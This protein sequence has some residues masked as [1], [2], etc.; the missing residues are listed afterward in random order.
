MKY[1]LLTII[2]LYWFIVPPKRRRKC[3]FKESCSN[4]VWRIT[5][6]NGFNAG[7]NA[8]L[9]RNRHCCPGYA[10]YKYNGHYNLKTI[11]GLILKDDEIAET[12]LNEKNPI[13]INFDNPTEN[14]N[15]YIN[16]KS[17]NGVIIKFDYNNFSN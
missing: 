9:F 4:Y 14:K 15:L 8:F 13:L 10:I 7:I 11:N 12:L 5:S 17:K 16:I 2:R 6:A 1:L 3:I